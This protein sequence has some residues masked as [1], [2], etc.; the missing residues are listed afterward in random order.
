MYL[1]RFWQNVFIRI[2]TMFLLIKFWQNVFIYQDLDGMYYFI[3][4]FKECHSIISFVQKYDFQYTDFCC[5]N[6]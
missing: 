6:F 1:S 3:E 4:I 5:C 2:F